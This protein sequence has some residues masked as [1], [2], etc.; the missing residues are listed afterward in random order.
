M[1][2]ANAGSGKQI[3]D[4]LCGLFGSFGYVRYKMNKFEEYELYAQNRSFLPS[5]SLKTVE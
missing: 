4:V 1:N 3:S 2:A 5:R